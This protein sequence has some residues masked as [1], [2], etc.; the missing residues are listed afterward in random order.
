MLN[1]YLKISD[2]TYDINDPKYTILL[3]IDSYNNFIKSKIILIK[4]N[5]VCE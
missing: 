3:I 4:T 1:I 5:S 2:N